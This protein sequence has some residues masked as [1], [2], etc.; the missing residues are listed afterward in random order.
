V[1]YVDDV[2]F[3][4]NDKDEISHILDYM[5]DQFTKITN[6]ATISK[7]VGIEIVRD[8]ENQTIFFSQKLY[9]DKYVSSNVPVLSSAKSIPLYKTVDYSLRVDST[10]PAILDKVGKLR[11]LAFW[12]RPDLL[13][14]VVLSAPALP[15]RQLTISV[16]LTTYMEISERYQWRICTFR[17][18]RSGDKTIWLLWFV[19]FTFGRLETK[20]RILL[21]SE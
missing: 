3:I 12:T 2:L 9:T 1:V 15:C 4:G 6:M 16:E 21:H 8:V 5:A 7:Y 11:Y 17:R 19:S 14:A 20:I 10:L 18:N 13:T